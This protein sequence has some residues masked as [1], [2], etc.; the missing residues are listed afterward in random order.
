MPDAFHSC[1]ITPTGISVKVL[2]DGVGHRQAIGVNDYD[3]KEAF[4]AAVSALLTDILGKN[5]ASVAATVAAAE[6]DA[7]AKVAALQADLDALGTKE[8]AQAIRD[9]QEKAKL[10]TTMSEAAAQ[11][12]ALEKRAR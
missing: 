6:T 5:L 1:E 3:T 10:R 8:E 4:Q 12:A 11:L 2:R 9:E 7:S